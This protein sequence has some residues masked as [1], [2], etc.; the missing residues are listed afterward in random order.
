LYA[1]R[2][3]DDHLKHTDFKTYLFQKIETLFKEKFLFWLETLS[4]T[5]NIGLAQSA[6]E[7]VN[8]WLASSQDVSITAGPM[9]NTNN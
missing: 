1:C 6:S 8:M 9:R 4:L 5:R 7:T 3:W 2:F